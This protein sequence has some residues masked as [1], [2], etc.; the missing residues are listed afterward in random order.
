MIEK[1]GRPLAYQS[2]SYEQL[3]EY[4]GAKGMIPVKKGWL[5]SIG[6]PIAEKIEDSAVESTASPTEASAIKYSIT[7]F[8]D[9]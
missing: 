9:E 3:G 4:I 7:R 1:R 6:F 8:E 5:E 2:V